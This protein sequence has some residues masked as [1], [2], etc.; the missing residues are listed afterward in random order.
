MKYVG[1]QFEYEGEMLTAPQVQKRV[2][3][4]STSAVH[5]YLREGAK[6]MADIHRIASMR[7]MRS[8]AQARKNAKAGGLN[9]ERFFVKGK[10]KNV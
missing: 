7:E 8:K 4:Y 9:N 1:E 2:P 10:S 6:N 5:R 3:A